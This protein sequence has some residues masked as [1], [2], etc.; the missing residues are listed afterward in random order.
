M[1]FDLKRILGKQEQKL[2]KPDSCL[3]RASFAFRFMIAFPR[4]VGFISLFL[5]AY[6]A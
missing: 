5:G 1:R 6:N 3:I 4:P 2:A